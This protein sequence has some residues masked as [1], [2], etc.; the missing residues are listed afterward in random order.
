MGSESSKDSQHPVGVKLLKAGN[1]T[2]QGLKDDKRY[3]EFKLFVN[4]QYEQIAL[5]SHTCQNY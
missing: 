5:V 4:D 3:G 1:W 2:S